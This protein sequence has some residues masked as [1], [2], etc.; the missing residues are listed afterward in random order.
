MSTNTL[1]VTVESTSDFFEGALADVRRLEDGEDLDD[2]YVLSLPDERALERVLNAKNLELLRTIAEADP[3]SVRDLAR[4]VE[5]DVKNVSVALN[6]LEALGL[7]RFER[8]GRAKRPRVWY[9]HLEIDLSFSAL[10]DDSD[11]AL[12]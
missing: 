12:A 7:V 2:E 5:R 11:T 10:D 4:R 6:E 8:D 9:D 1:H 3:A